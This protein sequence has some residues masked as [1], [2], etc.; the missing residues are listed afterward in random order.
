M[1]EGVPVPWEKFIEDLF[2]SMIKAA[3]PRNMFEFV[4]YLICLLSL[5]I[6]PNFEAFMKK[7]HLVW[8]YDY[9]YAL[10]L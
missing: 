4:I 9:L 1:V 5:I 7:T 8:F 10:T 6:S 2:L 3:G